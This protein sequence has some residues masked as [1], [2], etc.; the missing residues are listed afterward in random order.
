MLG[1]GLPC[2]CTGHRW[3]L[4]QQIS[5]VFPT[6]ATHT[7]CVVSPCPCDFSQGI[8]VSSHSLQT[9]TLVLIMN[10]F[11]R[12]AWFLWTF[13]LWMAGLGVTWANE[14]GGSKK[15]STNALARRDDNVKLSI[16]G[17]KSSQCLKMRVMPE[18]A[19]WIDSAIRGNP[20]SRQRSSPASW[21]WK[22]LF[23]SKHYTLTAWFF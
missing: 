3:A 20:L 10:V 8:P 14:P 5:H 9:D 12:T 1:S 23:R 22:Y 13:R 7:L 21:F 15:M 11:A 19:C 6:T 2:R 17:L 18:P 16:Q 4:S